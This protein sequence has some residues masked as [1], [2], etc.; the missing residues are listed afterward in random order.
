MISPILTVPASGPAS[1]GSLAAALEGGAVLM[2]PPVF[3][4]FATE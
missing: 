2:F 4:A 1:N 3:Q